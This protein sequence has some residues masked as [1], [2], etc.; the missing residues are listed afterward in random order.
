[1]CG[2]RGAFGREEG[3]TREGGIGGERRG[4]AYDMKRGEAEEEKGGLSAQG[5]NRT[6]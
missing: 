5:T 6:A 4:L 2:T 1:M 3:S